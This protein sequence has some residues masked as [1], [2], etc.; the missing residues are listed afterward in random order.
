MAEGNATGHLVR[1]SQ[2]KDATHLVAVASVS[3]ECVI[4]RSYVT[5]GL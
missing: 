1:V 3:A 4:Q 5:R 2:A